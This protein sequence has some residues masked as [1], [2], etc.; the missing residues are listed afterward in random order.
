MQFSISVHNLHNKFYL[1]YVANRIIVD[2]CVY[3]EKHRSNANRKL[4][5]NSPAYIR[6]CEYASNTFAQL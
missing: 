5:L 1:V 2:K 6:S 4:L 3:L